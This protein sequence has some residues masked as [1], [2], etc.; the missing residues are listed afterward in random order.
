M[1]E[2]TP[3]S[4]LFGGVLIGLSTLMLWLLDGQIAGISG[5]LGRLVAIRHEERLWCAAFILGLLLA[6]L[7]YALIHPLPPLSVTGSALLLIAAGL[8]VGFGTRL[9]DGCTS[10]HG[11]CGLARLSKRSIVATL[12]FMGVAAA[13]VFLARHLAPHVIG[14]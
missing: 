11:I 5:I 13:T 14:G 10:G 9:G 12:V 3:L 6:P 7:I 4:A 8:L 2:F 1:T